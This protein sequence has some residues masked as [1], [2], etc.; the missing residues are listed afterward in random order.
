MN[1]FFSYSK[2]YYDDRQ[3]NSVDCSIEYSKL[4]G[5]TLARISGCIFE[6]VIPKTIER[7]LSIS[8]IYHLEILQKKVSMSVLIQ[9]VNRLPDIT[10]L[11]IHSLSTDK[12]TELPV[13][14]LLILCSMTE[15]SKITKVNLEEIDNLQELD[16]L[17]TISPYMECFKVG[18]INAIDVQSLLRT[19]F[20]KINHNNHSLRT[21]CFDAPTAD[22]QIVENI[23][24]MIK[25]EKLL[26]DFTVK[27][28]LD[29]VYLQ[30][31]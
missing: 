13:K 14:E 22:H 3:D 4:P 26:P 21:L 9:A 15:T 30:W 25:C 29:T 18:C 27:H 31:I 17:F 24:E 23:E 20:R 28:I 8:Q 11:K 7:V 6:R 2:R 1:I 10:T 5:L 16:F 12:T 19:A